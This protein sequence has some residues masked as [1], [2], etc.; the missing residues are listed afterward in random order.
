MSNIYKILIKILNK[1]VLISNEYNTLIYYLHWKTLLKIPP[2][3][4]SLIRTKKNIKNNMLIKENF[5]IN[6]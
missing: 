2:P 1:N 5:P 4:K 6:N 3:H